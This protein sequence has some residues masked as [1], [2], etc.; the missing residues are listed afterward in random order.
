KVVPIVI[1]VLVIVGAMMLSEDIA[2]DR[3]GERIEAVVV[4][5]TVD[6]DEGV[7]RTSYTHH[8]V[9]ESTDGQPL[10]EPM[11]YRGK[12]GYDGVE[13]GTE[14]AVLVDPDGEV[15]TKPVDSI[16]FAADIALLVVGFL[17]VVGVFGAATIS[18][19]RAPAVRRR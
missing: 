3:A 16:D 10:D 9:L 8:Y 2:L 18:V 15:E 13:E 5:H 6:V 4:D 1:G 14:I 7:K 11:L 17:A 12:D 19:A